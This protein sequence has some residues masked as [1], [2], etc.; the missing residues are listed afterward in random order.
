MKK[1][2]DFKQ[3]MIKLDDDD[4][5]DGDENLIK[6]QLWD[7]AGQERFR[8]LTTAYYRGAMGIIV[9]YDVTNLESFQHVQYWFK[10]IDEVSLN[11]QIFYL[12]FLVNK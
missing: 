6:L 4:N 3:K 8:A 7:T 11:K 9:V 5:D 2:I 1:G 10:N 12:A